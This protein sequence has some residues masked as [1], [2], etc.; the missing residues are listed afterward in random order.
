M[1]GHRL[2]WR[3]EWEVGGYLLKIFRLSS[4]LYRLGVP[5]L[6]KMLYGI[7]RILF[8]VVLP[9][10][11]VVGRGTVFGYGG[12]G[13]VIHKR[14]ELG[15]NV[16]VGSNVTIGGRSGLDGVPRIEDEV[17]IGTGAKILGPVTIGR[18]A[19]VGANA[20]VLKDVAPGTTVVGIPARE[21][22]PRHNEPT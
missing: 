20:V 6:P 5:L 1:R 13:V 21:L 22:R 9:P 15:K 10:S 4:W 2:T 19:S 14:C 11:V 8:A 18:G 3:D 12:L 16:V 7:N 17:M